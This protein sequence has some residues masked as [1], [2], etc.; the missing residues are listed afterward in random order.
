MITIHRHYRLSN[1]PDLHAHV[2]VNPIGQ[3]DVEIV[4]LHEH[5]STEFDD[6]T[7]KTRGQKTQVCGKEKTLPWH[8]NLDANDAKDLSTVINEANEE[9][10]TLMR[11]LM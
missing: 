3:L 5:H 2:E 10:E 7:F 1:R 9:Y 8:L 6:L 4:E 11:D